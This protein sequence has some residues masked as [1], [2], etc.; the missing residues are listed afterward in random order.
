MKQRRWNCI[1]TFQLSFQKKEK[2]HRILFEISGSN[3]QE[4]AY[5]VERQTRSVDLRPLN[6]KFLAHAAQTPLFSLR[7]K[8]EAD[9]LSR[10]RE[11]QAD[12]AED[13]FGHLPCFP[14]D[15]CLVSHF[16]KYAR[17]SRYY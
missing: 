10:F 6:Q 13:R 8:Y 14:L 7:A 17:H 15:F 1:D 11:D 2:I 9:I 4:T 3:S 12:L 16:E 5:F